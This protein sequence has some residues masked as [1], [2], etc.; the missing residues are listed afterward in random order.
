[1]ATRK[2]SSTV[3]DTPR[4]ETC[5]LAVFD[6]KRDA[7]ECHLLPMQWY[8]VEGDLVARWSPAVRAGVCRMYERKTH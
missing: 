2:K 4:C 6:P 8:P 5:R 3:D 7:G 1:M